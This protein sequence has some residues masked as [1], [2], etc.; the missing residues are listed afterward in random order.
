MTKFKRAL[1]L[2]VLI[3]TVG[4]YA[5]VLATVNGYPIT[6]KEAD[7]FVK[8]ATRGKATY[9]MLKKKDRKRVIRMLAKRKLLLETA[10]KK[11]T[12]EQQHEAIVKYWVERS[13][14]KE[15]VSDE[16]VKKF[17]EKNKKRFFTYKK[18][19]N[20]GKAIPFEKI[21]NGL[22]FRMMQEKFI[23]NLLK[24]ATIDYNP[25]KKKKKSTTKKSTS[26]SSKKTKTT[27]KKSSD[28][29]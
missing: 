28:K 13:A 24:K 3:G 9:Y 7:A 16:E 19:E 23:K 22:K 25:G 2:L 5:K 10:K 6:Q 21:K 12:K 15:K 26:G 8:A 29:K 27:T 11:L 20:K 18:G 4:V 1:L 14:I 17:Y